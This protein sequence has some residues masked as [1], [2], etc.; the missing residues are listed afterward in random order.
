MATHDSNPGEVLQQ[1]KVIDD[2]LR[3][4][5]YVSQPGGGPED[6][7]LVRA[8]IARCER[9][10]RIA[11]AHRKDVDEHGGSWGACNECGLL[12]PC[13]TYEWAAADST[14]TSLDCWDPAD[15]EAAGEPD[16]AL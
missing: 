5:G 14:R 3:A 15:D 4:A 12:W 8:L 6:D 7:D 13:P 11:E 16:V 9:A 10:D 1:W 2:M